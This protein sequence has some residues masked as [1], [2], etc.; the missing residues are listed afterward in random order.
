MPFGLRSTRVTPRGR[1]L[2]VAFQRTSAARDV[3][4][5]VF[6]ESAGGRIGTERR[7]AT[8]AGRRR[9]FTWGGRSNQGGPRLRDGYVLLQFRTR[10]TKGVGHRNFLL[11]RRNGRFTKVWLY[12]V[13]SACSVLRVFSASRPVFGGTTGRQLGVVLRMRNAGRVRITLRRGARVVR[14]LASRRLSAGQRIRLRVR[15]R[16]LLRGAYLVRA[17]VASGGAKRVAVVTVRRL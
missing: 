10:T 2:R 3:R 4:V 8:F 16:G 5:N 14:K 17:D 12:T 13:K 9:S 6:Q 15:P 11:V 7:V 1:G